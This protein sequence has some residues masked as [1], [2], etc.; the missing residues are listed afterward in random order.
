MKTIAIII[1]LLVST[2]VYG[3]GCVTICSEEMGDFINESIE[4][5]EPITCGEYASEILEACVARYSG[6]RALRE[7]A[8][9]TQVG[10][11]PNGK[12]K[13]PR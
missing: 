3:Q 5:K 13:N 1:R 11:L 10:A 6:N 12:S 8:G 4:T 2:T 7:V 9:H